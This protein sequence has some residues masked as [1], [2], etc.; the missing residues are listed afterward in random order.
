[1]ALDARLALV[2]RWAVEW[3]AAADPRVGEAILAPDYAISISGQLL[4][5]REGYLAATLGQLERFPGLGLTVHELIVA[6]DRVALRFTQ[7][8]ASERRSGALAAWAGIAL[9]AIDDG[10][11]TRCWAEEDYLSR[12]R[13]LDSGPVDSI[14][15]PATSPWTT[16]PRNPEAG[17]VEVVRGWLAAGALTAVACD[18]APPG[19]STPIQLEETSVEVDEIFAAGPR[20]AFHAR[21]RGRYQGGLDGVPEAAHGRPAALDLAGILT[22]SGGAVQSGHIVR[23]RLGLARSLTEATR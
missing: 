4:D 2:R 15:A 5:G 8:G 3:L 16:T 14:A 1:M 9:F 7:H 19:V 10:H 22:V 11:L 6:G 21:R 23:D 13:Q 12:R 18:E 20:V 17:A